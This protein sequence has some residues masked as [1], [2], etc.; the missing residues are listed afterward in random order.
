MNLPMSFSNL[1][2]FIYMKEYK[3]IISFFV[4]VTLTACGSGST[5]PGT[6][7]SIP[8]T[9][10]IGKQIW[11]TKNLDVSTYRNGDTI[12]QV[13][14]DNTWND[15][16]TGAW[17]YYAKDQNEDKEDT[18]FGKLYNGYAV[19]DPRGLAP[20]GYRIPSDDEWIGL[21]NFIGGTWM[22]NENILLKDVAVKLMGKVDT[23]GGVY[24]QYRWWWWN[25]Y[26]T[27]ESGFSGLPGGLRF[28]NGK[29]EDAGH[30]GVWWSSTK[31][32]LTNNWIFRLSSDRFE[33]VGKSNNDNDGLANLYDIHG[34]QM[35]YSVRLIKD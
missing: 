29:F 28:S 1:F 16:T 24:K 34:L 33:R 15:L 22:L 13:S 17:C 11:T 4:I 6:T 23:A 14:D 30:F 18:I 5:V 10:K 35:G 32:G 12:P 20:I 21:M 27:N 31:D 7:D 3:I 26:G 8:G 2:L 25:N 9:V 19:N